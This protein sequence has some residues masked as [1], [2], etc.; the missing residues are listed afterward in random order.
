MKNNQS[1]ARDMAV[2]LRRF[3]GISN[4]SPYISL[5][6]P[7]AFRTGWQCRTMWHVSHW[8]IRARPGVAVALVPHPQGCPVWGATRWIAPERAVLQLSLRYKTNDH[9][10][11]PIF[12]G[13]AH[14]LRHG[15]KLLFL[16]GADSVSQS[17]GSW[18]GAAW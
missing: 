9:L 1:N 5:L 16:E 6:R 13:A 7:T 3:A 2:L 15:K 17:C 12:H 18:N 4:F 10:W 14:I 8:M 11:F